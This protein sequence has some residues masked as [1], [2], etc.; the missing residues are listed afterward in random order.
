M[1]QAQTRRLE[2]A[3]NVRFGSKADLCNAPTHVRFTLNSDRESGL[4]HTVMSA[5]PLKADVC[6]ANRQVCFGPKADSASLFDH[7]VSE[8]E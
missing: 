6:D 7:L 5:L 2:A 3:A 4:P 1:V 8:R